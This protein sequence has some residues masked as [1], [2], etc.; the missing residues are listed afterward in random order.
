MGLAKDNGDTLQW[1]KGWAMLMT[2]YLRKTMNEWNLLINLWIIL[3]VQLM[4]SPW[5]SAIFTVIKYP[6]EGVFPE[7]IIF[8]DS[9]PQIFDGTCQL[10]V[11][12]Y[13]FEP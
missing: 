4:C 12:I 5:K 3:Q 2:K 6:R 9:L 1:H 8:W 13:H 10:S 11:N 7:D